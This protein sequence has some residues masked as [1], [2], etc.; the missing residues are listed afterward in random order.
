MAKSQETM[1]KVLKH[2][3]FLPT[4]LVLFF[5]VAFM[6]LSRYPVRVDL[7]SDHR[8]TLSD[9]TSRL[10]TSLDAPLEIR[11]YLGEN[12]ERGSPSPSLQTAK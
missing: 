3:S 12:R 8:F 4:A 11:I 6:L 7:T 1:N 10:L 9:K 5:W 2:W